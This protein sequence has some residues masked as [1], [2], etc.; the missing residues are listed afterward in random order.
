[1]SVNQFPMEIKQISQH[2]KVIR[3]GFT[4]PKID[5][6]KE[7]TS[8]FKFGKKID[9]EYLLKQKGFENGR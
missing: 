3:F 5:P 4:L 8:V 9:I 1:M 6:W 7:I 2:M